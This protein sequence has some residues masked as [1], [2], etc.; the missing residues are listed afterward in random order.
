MPRQAP[1]SANAGVPD[2]APIDDETS[3]Q[4]FDSLIQWI[5]LRLETLRIDAI[6]ARA[7]ADLALLHSVAGRISSYDAGYAAGMCKGF[8]EALRE[9]VVPD[10]L[11]RLKLAAVCTGI[12]LD[13]M[14]MLKTKEVTGGN[15]I[16]R[17]LRHYLQS[18][19]V[20]GIEDTRKEAGKT[21]LEE[22]ATREVS[23]MS[24]EEISAAR[25]QASDR[26]AQIYEE[27]GDEYMA[28]FEEND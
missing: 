2:H 12:V 7:N 17:R 22:T 26:L 27:Y 5:R 20:Q 4:D 19:G 14:H 15:E 10:Y 8:M 21:S 16:D 9:E 28:N 23:G 11:I 1:T 3:L 24:L 13:I 25:Q 18:V 6:Q